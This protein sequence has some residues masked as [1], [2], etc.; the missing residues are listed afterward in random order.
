M[1]IKVERKLTLN[2]ETLSRLE[3]RR[4]AEVDG[5]NSVI[6]GCVTSCTIFVCLT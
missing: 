6:S 2:R 3:D 4:L 5:A 1:K